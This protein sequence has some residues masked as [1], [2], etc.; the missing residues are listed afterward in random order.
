MILNNM[1][2]FRLQSEVSELVR[3]RMVFANVEEPNV[4][5]AQLGNEEEA[6]SDRISGNEK[7]DAGTTISSVDSKVKK[8]ADKL[9]TV[10][11]SV[12]ALGVNLE[13][14]FNAYV[15]TKIQELRTL[16]ISQDANLG[17]QISETA[18]DAN[19]PSA[20]E[21][22]IKSL[23]ESVSGRLNERFREL[24][25][26]LDK[27]MLRV[28]F[29]QQ[30][31]ESLNKLSL[32]P[33]E[34]N[35][36]GAALETQLSSLEGGAIEGNSVVSIDQVKA[37]MAVLHEVT[38]YSNM[39]DACKKGTAATSLQ[40][41]KALPDFAIAYPPTSENGFISFE[42]WV[43]K[44]GN[45]DVLH[46]IDNNGTIQQMNPYEADAATKPWKIVYNNN[47][48]PK[49]RDSSKLNSSYTDSAILEHKANP[50]ALTPAQREQMLRNGMRERVIINAAD[51][52]FKGMSSADQTRLEGLLGSEL[53]RL[54]TA[55]NTL[56]QTSPGHASSFQPHVDLFK[57]F[58]TAG[59]TVNISIKTA[60]E[61]NVNY[62]EGLTKNSLTGTERATTVARTPEQIREARLRP[63]TVPIMDRRTIA[64][65]TINNGQINSDIV[66]ATVPANQ[67][68]TETQVI[69]KDGKIS[70][71]LEIRDGKIMVKK[72]SDISLQTGEI[73]FVL[74]AKETGANSN[75][76]VKSPEYKFTNNEVSKSLEDISFERTLNRGPIPANDSRPI[77]NIKDELPQGFSID[78]IDN[79]DFSPMGYI[80]VSMDDFFRVE[81]NQVFYKGIAEIPEGGTIGVPVK[82]KDAQGN[83][84]DKIFKITIGEEKEAE[85][86]SNAPKKAD[87][88]AKKTE[89]I[90]KKGE[91]A[92]ATPNPHE[93]PTTTTDST[94][95]WN[96]RIGNELR[97]TWNS[98]DGEIIGFTSDSNTVDTFTL[99]TIDAKSGRYFVHNDNFTT[100]LNIEGGFIYLEGG[101]PGNTERMRFKNGPEGQKMA[102]IAAAGLNKILDLTINTYGLNNIQKFDSDGKKGEYFE[103]DSG[104]IQVNDDTGMTD[105]FDQSLWSFPKKLWDQEESFIKLGNAVM[106]DYMGKTNENEFRELGNT[107]H[108]SPVETSLDSVSQKAVIGRNI[109]FTIDNMS[110]DYIYSYSGNRMDWHQ[111][112]RKNGQENISIP[113]SDFDNDRF[114]EVITKGDKDYVRITII[115]SPRDPQSNTNRPT[116]IQKDLELVRAYETGRTNENVFS[117]ISNANLPHIIYTL[118]RDVESTVGGRK[119]T[120]DIMTIG[121]EKD[122]EGRL[123]VLKNNEPFAKISFDA[124]G[125]PDIDFT[126]DSDEN[127]YE[128]ESNMTTGSG[129]ADLKFTKVA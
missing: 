90:P 79:T 121:E 44:V 57:E 22:N 52:N 34:K 106:K 38:K 6:I 88:V 92:E 102:L 37:R 58:N 61:A 66:V 48:D 97:N 125:T 41:S 119:Y 96:I 110:E 67:M 9:N 33:D 2:Y 54:Q 35:K 12:S 21:K 91:K 116:V 101:K 68:G 108:E 86:K 84:H 31:A 27:V 100:Q 89:D 87:S 15:N 28:N 115:A 60:T 112:P 73:I 80:N 111:I 65:G 49:I 40:T 127:I 14:K 109:D 126:R 43:E 42:Y 76:W 4:P 47:V 99:G 72:N 3:K 5:D 98:I 20:S 30:M 124:D 10:Q 25:R 18:F 11:S 95:E 56:Y 63:Q 93:M 46:C 114:G 104:T 50:D 82:I 128:W 53:N 1:K 129:I 78:S 117:A 16:L 120:S 62:R 17:N 24:D 70:E 74:Q 107:D 83:L 105:I 32:T 51:R 45:D 64:L 103:Y 94:E 123:I 36:I 23:M 59:S 75:N 8:I 13:T 29:R 118:K 69:D 122:D 81:D 77:L 71:L 26:G 19:N 55:H 85:K 113:F 39:V 7:N